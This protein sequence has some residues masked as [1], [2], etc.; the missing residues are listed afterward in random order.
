[1]V[2]EEYSAPIVEVIEIV[3]EKGFAATGT[4]GTG[5]DLPWG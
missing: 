4:E 2:R 1:M 5:S 3:V